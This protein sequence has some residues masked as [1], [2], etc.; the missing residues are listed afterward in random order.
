MVPPSHPPTR[1]RDVAVADLLRRDEADALVRDAHLNVHRYPAG[2]PGL[3]VRLRLDGERGTAVGR[4]E[5][6]PGD[7]PRVELTGDAASRDWVARELGSI[8]ADRWHRPYEDGDGRVG[9]DMDE[10]GPG[11]LGT[12]VHLD[13]AMLSTYWI[14]NGHITRISRTIPAGRLTIVIQDHATAPDGTAVATH[15]TVT[16]QDETTGALRSVDVHR[17]AHVERW[18]VLVPARRR[19]V[20]LTP[21]GSSVRDLVIEHHELLDAVAR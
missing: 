3:R 8:A 2:F 10:S 19:V 7:A 13:D 11:P 12:V 4:A 16:V 9:K 17:D 1:E 15:F 20:S 18:G 14:E 6:R 5:L 21:E